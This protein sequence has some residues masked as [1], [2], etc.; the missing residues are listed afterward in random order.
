MRARIFGLAV[1]VV[2]VVA[3]C[4]PALAQEPAAKE[5]PKWS[6]A[7]MEIISF[8]KDYAEAVVRGNV[9]EIM[10]FMHPAFG[11]WDLSTESPMDRDSFAKMG[12]E[13]EVLA[14]GLTPLKVDVVGDVAVAYCS[15]EESWKDSD[16]KEGHQA[17]RLTAT[18]LKHDGKWS[19]L[20]GSWIA[21]P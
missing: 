18:F 14:F 3:L 2:C 8:F 19:R 11:A 15:Y 17:G 9:S 4:S 5:E 10:A 16:G 13:Y 6:A 7:Q 21:T 20:H 12:G 1:V